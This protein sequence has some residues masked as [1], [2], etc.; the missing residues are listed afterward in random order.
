MPCRNVSA[1]SSFF[2]WAFSRS[3]P[4]IP[5][6]CI[7]SRVLWTLIFLRSAYVVSAVPKCFSLLPDDTTLTF[8]PFMTQ[9]CTTMPC[10]AF[11]RLANGPIWFSTTTSSMRNGNRLSYSAVSATANSTGEHSLAVFKVCVKWAALY[12]VKL[13]SMAGRSPF[14]RPKAAHISSRACLFLDAKAVGTLGTCFLQKK[15]LPRFAVAR[16][17][18]GPFFPGHV[19]ADD[20]VKSTT[21]QS[22]IWSSGRLKR[23][24]A[25]LR[26]PMSME[27][28]RIVFA[29]NVT[30][31]AC[32]KTVDIFF[33]TLWSKNIFC[34][35]NELFDDWWSQGIRPQ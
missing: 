7:R 31:F 27:R 24:C 2:L 11:M 35:K 6:A 20:P 29:A 4:A 14:S 9:Y 34:N 1:K 10:R 33:C 30:T 5:L 17:P 16:F 12:A 23:Q 22:S 3:M 26:M 13:A 25:K 19:H 18:Q 8:A 21:S 32:K 15:W 28:R